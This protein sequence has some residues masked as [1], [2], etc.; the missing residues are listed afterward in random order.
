[1]D[2]MNIATGISL[3]KFSL[4]QVCIWHRAYA[5]DTIILTIMHLMRILIGA[6]CGLMN[7]KVFAAI[8]QS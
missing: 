2:I 6:A 7:V 5:N 3:Q 8:C 1:M 4:Y